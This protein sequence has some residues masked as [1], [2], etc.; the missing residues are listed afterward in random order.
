M[1]E[2]RHTIH[3]CAGRILEL[4]QEDGRI[5]W[6]DDGIFD[7][8]NHTLSAMAL[9]VAG[10]R[11]AADRAFAVLAKL[12]EKDGALPGQCGASAPLDAANRHLVATKAQ[13]LVDTNFT[14]FVATGLWHGY[15]L[16]GDKDWLRQYLPL[17]Q[18]SVDFV[19]A[20]QSP[21]GE[22]AWRRRERHEALE[23]VDALFTGN[24][25]LFKSLSL[26]RRIF[27]EL[28]VPA[29]GLNAAIANL[30]NA[31]LH[32]S[33]RFDRSWESKGRFAMDWYYP[34]LTGVISGQIAHDHLLAR[35]NEFVDFR[36]GCRCVNDQ[37]WFTSAETCELVMALLCVGER[38][39][40]GLLMQALVT[41]RADAGGYWMGWQSQEQIFWPMERPG[42]TAAAMVL[43]LD[44]LHRISPAW[45]V[46][47][48]SAP[49]QDH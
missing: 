5:F 31:L 40:A 41:L 4:Q 1:D 47:L 36:F 46:L 18:R 28:D 38:E 6:I 34:V 24:C 13:P 23:E 27:V 14:G 39:K 17:L 37:P 19:L 10:E 16:N 43:A 49:L 48:G 11:A 42:W 3:H 32:K 2:V 25:A 29:S 22:I 21:H 7:P 26:A 12:Q 15:C 30:H 44:A 33:W 20:H 8:W 9:H 45:D 35:M